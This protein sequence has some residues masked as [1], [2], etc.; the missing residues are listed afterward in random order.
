MC[1]VLQ[2]SFTSVK[3]IKNEN[4]QYVCENSRRVCDAVVESQV[5]TTLSDTW[6]VPPNCSHNGC[7][8][9]T[10]TACCVTHSFISFF[11]ILPLVF[12]T[13]F[14]TL[15]SSFSLPYFSLVGF[16]CPCPVFH[17]CSSALL[18][19]SFAPLS[20]LQIPT[21]PT[22]PPNTVFQFIIMVSICLCL[23]LSCLLLSKG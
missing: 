15:S 17:H 10:E 2:I 18:L 3:L 4:I 21:F 22:Q 12:I 11:C 6:I 20:A 19:L 23:V 8:M 5:E 1:C 9:Q 13:F 14:F 7:E 16:I